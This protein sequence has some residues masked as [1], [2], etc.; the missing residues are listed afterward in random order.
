M[1]D[2]KG[3]ERF[4]SKV[5]KLGRLECWNWLAGINNGGYGVFYFEGAFYPAHRFSWLLNNS[6]P[7]GLLVLHVCGNSKCVNPIH[8]YCG[9]HK[10]NGEDRSRHLVYRAL[11]WM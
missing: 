5:N 4:W 9:T 7:V 2:K 10:D 3:L 1:I 11:G 8:L 6:I